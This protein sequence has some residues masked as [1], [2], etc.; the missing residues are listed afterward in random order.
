M[1]QTSSSSLLCSSS[2]QRS[3]QQVRGSHPEPTGPSWPGRTMLPRIQAH[4]PR[5]GTGCDFKIICAHT[6]KDFYFFP[7]QPDTASRF[8]SGRRRW[9]RPH[10]HGI[11]EAGEEAGSSTEPS[12]RAKTGRASHNCLPRP[13]SP[14]RRWRLGGCSSPSTAGAHM[15]GLALRCAGHL[16]LPAGAGAGALRRGWGRAKP[17]RRHHAPQLR[18]PS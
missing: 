17:S 16:L 12:S 1:L 6:T 8:N 13:G 15:P 7:S 10:K 9:Q 5:Q 3:L 4:P 14:A 11:L 2:C 18:P